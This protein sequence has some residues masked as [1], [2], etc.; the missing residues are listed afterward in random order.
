MAQKKKPHG[1]TSVAHR[2]AMFRNEPGL[3]RSIARKYG[4]KVGGGFSQKQ[5]KRR[6]SAAGK[7]QRYR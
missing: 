6:R 1:F 2:K 4:S 7:G 3:A 5:M